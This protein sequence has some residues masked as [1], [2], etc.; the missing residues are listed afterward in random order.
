MGGWLS[1]CGPKPTQATPAAPAGGKSP[2]NVTAAGTTTNLVAADARGG[3]FDD[4]PKSGGKDPFF[5]LSNRRTPAV[6]AAPT[7]EPVAARPSAL[8]NYV[9]LKGVLGTQL[10]TFKHSSG[11]VTIEVGDEAKVRL[12]SGPVTL[13]LL[14]IKDESAIVLVNGERH[15]LTL[16][17]K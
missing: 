10:A 6:A 17:K 2:T 9:T 16:L 7:T 12:P 3:K 13:K 4:D 1:G 5:P 15:V 14:E 8:T 11:L